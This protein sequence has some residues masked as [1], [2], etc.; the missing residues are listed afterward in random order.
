MA[1]GQKE[2]VIAFNDDEKFYLNDAQNTEPCL[3]TEGCL[4]NLH[5]AILDK[6]WVETSIPVR[7]PQGCQPA[8]DSYH[9][10]P[11]QAPASGEYRSVRRFFFSYPKDSF[12]AAG[13]AMIET[14]KLDRDT[15]QLWIGS[16]GRIV[17]GAGKFQ[18][19][20]GICVYAGSAKVSGWPPS[21][22]GQLEFLRR[23]D[24]RIRVSS[25]VRLVL[26]DD[27]EKG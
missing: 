10:L 23:G 20:R 3:V 27:L 13:S 15:T 17:R 21:V 22:A 7:L 18:G 16:T 25:L 1:S 9:C 12:E 4:A 6:S 5:N 26:R 24:L 8:K 19:A 2:H 14:A 11:L